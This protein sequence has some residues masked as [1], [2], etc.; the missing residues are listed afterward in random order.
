MEQIN[1]EII[2]KKFES[3]VGAGNVFTSAVDQLCYSRDASEA[4]GK[5]DLIIQPQ[6]V[7]QV[8]QILSYAY[9]NRVPVTPRGAGTSLSGGSIS[10]QGGILMDMSKMNHIIEVNTSDMQAYV[11]V[12]VVITTL[13]NYLKRFG[14]IFPPDP[15]SQDTCTIGGC[16]AENSGGMRA[17]KYGTTKT[18]IMELEVVL[19]DGRILHTGSRT[20]KWVS[21]YDL[22]SLF[23]GSEGTL[24]V[25]TK[26]RLR[27]CKPPEMRRMVSSFFKS[28]EDAGK[29]VHKIMTSGLEPSMLEFLDKVT[30]DAISKTSGLKFPEAQA[31]LLIEVDGFKEAIK[32]KL[33]IL[34]SLLRSEDAVDVKIASTEIEN[35]ELYKARKAAIPSLA[36][37]GMNSTVEDV[38]VPISQIPRI[39]MA[40]QDLSNKYNLTIGS[41]GHMGDG[42][43]HPVIIYN[44][45]D[46]G[47]RS[48]VKRLR[49]DLFKV[50]VELGGTL[51]GEHGIGRTKSHFMSLEHDDVTIAIMKS[52]KS[53]LDPYNIMNPQEWV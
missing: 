3:F 35:E 6:T 46:E 37:L 4:E 16:I 47:E 10:C 53:T 5:P 20:R 26:A 32:G 2:T 31:M 9:E 22:L 52:I 13:N 45:Q 34:E 51:T 1:S 25:I 30:L 43:T 15:S 14:F 28:I 38:T 50:A 42:N 23:I 19:P 12:G 27:L 48:R 33:S 29:A 7:E 49:E 21:G 44:E 41:L 11:E 40:I 24:G 18:W 17:V 36:T 8:S 39:L